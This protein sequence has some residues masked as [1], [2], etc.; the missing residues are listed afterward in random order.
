MNE[1]QNLASGVI[2]PVC[3]MT[4]N[5]ATASDSVVHA[6]KTYYFWCKHCAER[7]KAAPA[8][9]LNK[10][11]KPM[12]GLVTLGMPSSATSPAGKVKDPVC[13]MDVDPV[14]A[15]YKFEHQGKSYFFCSSGC[16]EKFRKNPGNYLNQSQ[17]QRA[18]LAASA[19]AYVCPMCP[20]VRE[21][22]P[23]ACPRCGMALEPESPI[24]SRI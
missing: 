15:K 9:Y 8:Q 22:K 16:L 1:E 3:G 13:G 19:N 14:K 7:F 2:D 10:P 20:E 11:A 12:S 23:V 4:V 6:G 18:N 17:A 24:S 21:S 5:P